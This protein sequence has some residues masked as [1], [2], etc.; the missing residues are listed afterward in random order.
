MPPRA[1]TEEPP[2]AIKRIGPGKPFDLQGFV[3]AELAAGRTRI[4]IPPGRHRVMP[5]RRQHLVIADLEGV[6]ID[7][8]GA[9]M[10]CTETTRA[11]TVAKCR[12][13]TVRGLTIDYDP[14]PFT[15]GRIVSISDDWLVHDIRLFEGYPPADRVV[16]KKYEIFRPDTRTLRAGSYHGFKVEKLSARRIRVTKPRHYMKAR[17]ERVGDVIVIAASHAPGGSIPHAVFC[18]ESVRV[19]FEDVTLYGSNCFGFFESGCEGCVYRRCRIDRRAPE[20]DIKRRENPRVRSLNADAYHSKHAVVGPSYLECS[21][22]FMGD[23]CVA[24]NGDYHMVMGASGRVLRVLGKNNRMNIAPGDRLEIVSYTGERLPDAVATK[25][26]TDADIR[27]DERVFLLKQRMHAPFKIGLRKAFRIT[28]DREVE[29]A[30]GSVVCSA[31][32][33]GN[34]FRVIGCEMGFNRSRGILVKAG[35]GEIRGNRMEGCWMEAIR[36]SPEWWWL[37]AGSGDDVTI[38]GNTIVNCRKTGISVD[39]RGGSGKVAPA[40]AHNRITITGNTIKNVPS[41]GI[42]VTS[43][44]GLVLEGNSVTLAPGDEGERVELVNCEDVESE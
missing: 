21:A 2:V 37:E 38:A 31:R 25:V 40:G 10:V 41:P 18:G 11:L 4:V 14:L 1:D 33:I 5:R 30:R 24:I 13:V 19:T 9:E 28:L 29:L 15:Q 16:E 35:R 12:D 17:H 20:T 23:D 43:T 3:D 36:L 32:R 27:D 42:H 8:R 7:A 44:R 6:V 26:E 22:R 39:A 34:G